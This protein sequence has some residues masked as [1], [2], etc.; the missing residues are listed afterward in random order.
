MTPSKTTVTYL[1]TQFNAGTNEQAATIVLRTSDGNL[2]N[3]PATVTATISGLANNSVE[4]SADCKIAEAY[5]MIMKPIILGTYKVTIKV[6]GTT[7]NTQTVT[8]L[9]GEAYY[10][11]LPNNSDYH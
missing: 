3:Y 6:N 7:A 2:Y 4:V 1:K 5:S 11:R 9:C 8:I 10:I